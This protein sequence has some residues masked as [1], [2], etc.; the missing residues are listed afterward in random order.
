MR[1]FSIRLFLPSGS[2][3]GIL[4][5]TNDSWPGRAVVYPRGLAGEVKERQEYRQ[6]GVYALLGQKRMYIGGGDPVGDCLDSDAENKDFWHKAVFFTAEGGRLDK[7]HVQYLESRLIAL[8]KDSGRV[9]LVHENQHAAPGLS[10]E[11]YA[12]AERFLYEI[13]QMLPLLGFHHLSPL[14]Y[15]DDCD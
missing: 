13:L 9:S 1:P 4:V 5:A 12:F 14:G 11:G 15:V 10:E 8:A 3:D 7:A 2:P 6:P